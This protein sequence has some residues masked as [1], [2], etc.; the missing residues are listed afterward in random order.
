MIYANRIAVIPEE[1]NVFCKKNDSS[2]EVSVVID[3]YIYKLQ[4]EKET[5]KTVR[6]PEIVHFGIS[7]AKGIFTF[8]SA[9]AR[10]SKS[11]LAFAL[12]SNGGH[13]G[14]AIS[15]LGSVWVPKDESGLVIF[16]NGHARVWTEGFSESEVK[17]VTDYYSADKLFA[18]VLPEAKEYLQRSNAK[19]KLVRQV[20]ELDSLAMIEA[21]LDLLTRYILTGEGK[22]ILSS[23]VEDNM[24]TSI[25]TDE[26]LKQTIQ[27][28][29]SY[30][31]KL[32][33][34]YFQ[35]KGDF[36]NGNLSS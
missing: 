31:R 34:K 7:R 26:K 16:F 15:C 20:N 4:M 22:E 21:Q 30:L 35:E 27:R 33:K 25:H 1:A 2:V 36:E 23:A 10:E 9:E 24:V 17:Q 6:L 8:T 19:R 14:T 12:E 28:Q 13:C 5:F 18:D 32:Q 29:K 11:G 3:D